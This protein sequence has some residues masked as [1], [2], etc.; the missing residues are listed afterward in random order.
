MKTPSKNVLCNIV[1]GTPLAVCLVDVRDDNWRITYFN[2]A[3]KRLLGVPAGDINGQDAAPLISEIGGS[4]AITAIDTVS[5]VHPQTTF[6]GV[7]ASAEGPDQQ[8]TGRVVLAERGASTRIVYFELAD[9]EPAAAGSTGAF[10]SLPSDTVTVFL[11]PEPWFALL[12]RDAAIAARDQSWLAVIVFRVDSLDSYIDTFGPHAGDTALKRISH[13]IRRRL[14]RAGDTAARVGNDEIAVLVHSTTG[15]AARKFAETIAA[16][17]QALAIHHPKSPV[18]RHLS[19]S[20]G[21]CARIPRNE[22]DADS[23]YEQA[24]HQLDAP[25]GVVTLYPPL[26]DAAGDD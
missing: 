10:R 16:D 26:D 7:L 15:P 2:P 23:M 22:S 1:D 24:R 25:E 9:A 12:H 3:F 19:L 20:V 14:Q 21:V 17:V 4:G 11:K 6:H 13:S 18:G 8:I 5:E